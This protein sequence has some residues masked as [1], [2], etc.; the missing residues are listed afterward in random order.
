MAKKSTYRAPNMNEALLKVKMDLG[1]EAI[2]EEKREVQQGGFLGFFQETL[3]EVDAKLPGTTSSLK[4]KKPTK[5]KTGQKNR[6][7]WEL[8]EPAAPDFSPRAHAARLIDQK[9]KNNNQNT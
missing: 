9:G 7:T 8:N 3:V 4:N 5:N 6:K 2:I 1:S